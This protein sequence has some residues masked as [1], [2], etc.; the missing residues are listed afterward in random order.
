MNTLYQQAFEKGDINQGMLKRMQDPQWLHGNYYIS[1]WGKPGTVEPC[2]LNFGGHHIA[3]N[4]TCRGNQV[5]MSLCFVGT[6]PAE[7]KSAKYAGLQALSKE[8]DLINYLS[9]K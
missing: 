2:G 6:D 8:E 3:L 5:V 7:V 4:L 1:V 9:D